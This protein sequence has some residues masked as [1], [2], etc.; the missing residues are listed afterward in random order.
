MLASF[1]SL[2]G[3]LRLESTS[4]G[5]FVAPTTRTRAC[6]LCSPSISPTTWLTILLSC[7]CNPCHLWG[8][9]T[10]T[11]SSKTMQG[12]SWLISTALLKISLRVSSLSPGLFPAGA[13]PST[14]NRW[15]SI[16]S[17]SSFTKVVLPQPGGPLKS[18]PLATSTPRCWSCS[19][20][21]KASLATDLRVWRGP[22][23]PAR[24]VPGRL[25][26]YCCKNLSRLRTLS[27]VTQVHCCT[28]MKWHWPSPPE[29]SLMTMYGYHTSGPVP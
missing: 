1:S 14:H 2:P 7:R 10:S 21:I 25:R 3:L 27:M 13:P 16:S 5:L 15:A 12:P 29:V 26:L 8:H 17:A 4:L 23:I 6:I 9:S 20:S 11:S 18:T 19:V 22:S 28:V 24:R